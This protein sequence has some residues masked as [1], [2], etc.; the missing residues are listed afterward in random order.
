[1]VNKFSAER[2]VKVELPGLETAQGNRVLEY[3]LDGDTWERARLVT[4][5]L[6]GRVKL[7]R[8]RAPG[9][10][11]WVDLSDLRFRWVS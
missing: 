11:A 6:D 1:M 7:E 4:V 8:E 2:L 9:R 5:A 10:A 3:T